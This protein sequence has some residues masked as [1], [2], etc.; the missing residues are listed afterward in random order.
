MEKKLIGY[1]LIKPEYVV[2]AFDVLG[3]SNRAFIGKLKEGFIIETP[4][5]DLSIRKVKE[6]GV[7]DLWFEPVYEEVKFKV[8]DWIT[9]VKGSVHYCGE[10]GKSYEI[11]DIDERGWLY[12]SFNYA[13]DPHKVEV[14][15]ATPEEIKAAQTPQIEINGYK[16]EFFDTYVV[17]GCAQ[18]SKHVFIELANTDK[19]LASNREIESVTIGKGVFSMDVIKEIADYYNNK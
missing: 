12:Y 2:A 19:Y 6:A 9:V 18:I 16:A 1:K 7:L 5:K 17:F 10:E 14:R 15:H 3:W 13:I 8:G 4:E 11:I